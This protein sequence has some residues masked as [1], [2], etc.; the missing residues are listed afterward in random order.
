MA[1]KTR[2]TR[3]ICL[4]IRGTNRIILVAALLFPS[5]ARVTRANHVFLFFARVIPGV[6]VEVQSHPGLAEGMGVHE[7]VR[8]GYP[9]AMGRVLG[10]RKPQ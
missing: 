4:A 8:A 2:S 1:R 7:A 6:T 10:D 9:P 3:D 5:L